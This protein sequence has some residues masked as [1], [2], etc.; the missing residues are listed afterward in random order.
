[1]HNASKTNLPFI[2]IFKISDEKKLQ[3]N[4]SKSLQVL[5][6]CIHNNSLSKQ[7]KLVFFS[8]Y[9]IVNPLVDSLYTDLH[10]II[11]TILSF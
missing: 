4:T 3:E 9:S 1:M 8:Y 2:Y 5:E 10:T 7:N 6:V 11:N